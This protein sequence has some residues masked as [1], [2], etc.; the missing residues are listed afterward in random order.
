MPVDA[1]YEV[2]EL[3]V[4]ENKLDL[5]KADAETLPTLSI[6]KVFVRYLFCSILLFHHVKAAVRICLRHETFSKD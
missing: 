4:P 6:G 2:K 5:V 3:Y 1:S